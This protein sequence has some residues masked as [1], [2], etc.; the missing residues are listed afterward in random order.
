MWSGTVLSHELSRDTQERERT[1]KALDES[2]RLLSRTFASLRDALLIVTPQNCVIL[3]ANPA[4][5]TLF[6]YTREEL[7]GHS[8]RMLYADETGFDSFSDRL[9]NQR[10]EKEYPSLTGIRMRRRDGEILATEHS[11]APLHAE[12]GMLWGWVSVIRD[13]TEQARV[14][15][16]LEQYRGK[17]RALAAELNSVEARGRKAVAAELH[18]NLGQLLAT[19]KL[20]IGALANCGGA[21]QCAAAGWQERVAEIRALVEEA[22]KQTRSLTYQLSPPILYQLGLEAA[23]KWL[24]E[25]MQQQYGYYVAFSRQ[26][27]SAR[28][29]E[30]TSVFLFSAVRE[31]FVNV[32]KHAGARHSALRLRWLENAVE[33]LV[34]DDGRGFRA[35]EGSASI[36]SPDGFG[37]FNIQERVSGLGGRMWLRSAPGRG[38]AVK[39]RLPLSPSR[40]IEDEHPN[41]IS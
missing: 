39:I 16:K 20:K 36:G 9:G 14:Q 18:E 12:D 13:V 24:A 10:S 7:L 25:N 32:A 2:Q 1:A 6:G 33:V 37:L 41:R 31:L 19:A 30:E 40:E 27:E 26:G 5:T 22:L 38:A 11:V 15:Q 34:A 3:D 4:A 35:A 29:E 8:A 17:L 21:P 28:L 23:L